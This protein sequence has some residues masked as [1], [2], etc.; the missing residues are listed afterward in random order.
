MA[1][2]LRGDT[3]TCMDRLLAISKGRGAPDNVTV[4]L[5]REP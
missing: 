1:E 3:E 4:V 5:A 2:V